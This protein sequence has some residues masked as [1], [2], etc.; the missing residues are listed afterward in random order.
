MTL[1][2][3]K[4]NKEAVK[5]SIF[6][7]IALLIFSAI[8]VFEYSDIFQ[9]EVV[10]LEDVLGISSKARQQEGILCD[11]GKDLIYYPYRTDRTYLS[12]ITSKSVQLFGAEH[13]FRDQSS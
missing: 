8:G 1:F 9:Y 10:N 5:L 13:N 11:V 2:I 4:N 3:I 7:A 6:I 12:M